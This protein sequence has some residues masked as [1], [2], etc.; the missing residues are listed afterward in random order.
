MQ[1]W[2]RVMRWSI[3]TFLMLFL[4]VS[5]VACGGVAKISGPPPLPAVESLPNPSLPD[6]IEQISPLGQAEPLAQVR[7]LFKEALI[8]I[9]RLDSPNQQDLLKKFEIIPPIAGQF[10]FLTPRMVGFQ[11]EE[12]LPKATRFRVTLKTGLGDLKNHR[13]DRDLIWTFNTEPIKFTNLPGI[14]QEQTEASPIDLKPVLTANA[15]V[16]LDLNSLQEHVQLIP[17]QGKPIAVKAALK[18]NDADEISPQE[19]FDPSTRVWTYTLTPQ[20]QL[21]KATPYRLEFQ[22]GIR[23]QRGNLATAS[24]IATSVSTYAPLKFEGLKYVG[25]PDASGAYGR[26]TQGSAQ[27]QF[28]NP[29]DPTS[30]A[31]SIRLNPAPKEAP[32]LVQSYEGERLVN[33]NPWALDPAKTYSVTID[34]NLKDQFGQSLGQSVTVKYATGDAAADI[35]APNNLNI[36]PVGKDLE[37][38][39]ETINLP[40][41]QY[42]AAF[43]VIQPQELVYYDSAYPQGE[44]PELLPADSNW[45]TYR[46]SGS[47][48]NQTKTLTVPL[49]E[50]LGGPTGMLAYGIKARTNRY[51]EEGKQKW[52][53]PKTYGMV[54]VTNLGVFTQWFPETG[55]IRVHHLSDGSPV[56]NA[57]IEVY[58]SRLR[59]ADR[60][61]PT[62]C[63]TGK[64]DANGTLR[65]NSADVTQCIQPNRNPEESGG[66]EVL[67]I[68]RENRDWAFARVENYSGAYGYGLDAGWQDGKP[69]SRGTIF[70]D[71]Q[72]YQP[73]E[74]AWFTGVAYYLQNDQIQTDRTTPYRV[75]LRLPDGQTVDLGTQTT[76]EFGTFSLEW[77]IKPDQ[78]LGF[79]TI[80]AKGGSG[81]EITGEFRVAEF[82]PPNFKVDLNLDRELVTLNQKVEAKTQSNYLFGSPVEGG[83][84]QYY[85][86]REA[87]DFKPKG[88]DPFSFGQQWFWPEEKPRVGNEVLLQTGNLSA[89]GQSKQSIAVTQDLPYPMIYRV[90]AQVTDVSN[91]SVADSKTFTVLPSDRLIGLQSDFVADAEK[92]FSVQVVV[93]DPT[94]KP[95]EGQTVKLELQQ[96]RY[97]AVTR[98]VE[99]S[100]DASNQ[101]EY[102]TVGQTDVRSGNQPQTVSLTPP[103][104]GSYRIRANFKD[105][106]NEVAVTDVQIWATGNDPV[107]WGGRYT[108]NRLEI[109]LDKPTYQ[110]G[111]TATALIQSPYPEAELYFAVVRHNTLYQ[112]VVKVQGSAPQVQFQ[113]TPDMLPNAAV[114]AVLVR[115][116]PPLAQ[117]QPGSLENLVK[118]GFAPFK[119]SVA[120][121][122]LQVQITPQQAELQPGAEQTL[123][124]TLQDLQGQPVKGQL[125][126]V[127]VNEAI[128]Q[129]SGY[130]LPDLVETVYAEQPIS[131]RFADNRPN[132]VLEPIASPL[133][134]GWGYGGGKSA[135]IANTRVRKNFQPLAF[136][137]GAIVTNDQG[138]AQV[139]FKLPDDL[140]TW[141]VMAVAMTSDLRFGRSD[142]TFLTTQPLLSNPILP[143]FARPGDR[144]QV[145]LAVTNTTGQS[146]TINL[147][148]NLNG[149]LQF[150]Q[151]NPAP[152]T[153]SQQAQIGSGTSAYRFPIVVQS[154]GEAKVSFNTQLNGQQSDAFEVPLPIQTLEVTEQVVETGTTT[155][156]AKIP[157]NLDQ[158]VVPNVGGL[159]VS[160]ASTLVSAIT[161][162]A[163]QVLDE[164]ELPFLEP[165]ASQLAIAANL[166]TLTRQY[167]QTIAKFNAGQQAEQAMTRL[168][169]L[170][171]SDGGFANWPQQEKSDP[172]V[173]AYAAQAIANAQR[174]GLRVDPQMVSRLQTYLKAILANPGQFEFC[175]PTLCKNQI[176]LAALTALA[177]LG[178][179]RGD[180][181]ADLYGDRNNLDLVTQIRL[182]RHLARFPEWQSEATTLTNQLQEILYQSGRSTQINLPQSWRWLNS[183]TTAQ[184]EAVRLFITQKAKPE[185]IDRLVRGLLELRRQGT[186]QTSYDN[187]VALTALVDYL[188]LQPTPPNFTATVQLGNQS[189]GTA[190]FEGYQQP[191][192]SL[193]MPMADLPKGRRELTLQK[194]GQ[195][196]LH[197]LVSY[198]YR[199]N[200]PQPGRL[201]GLRVVRSIHPANQKQ[202]IQRFGLYPADRP[203]TLEAGQVFDIG[204]EIIT[205]H[206]VDH[207]LITDPLPAGLEAVDTSFQTST[208]YFQ[209]QSDSWQLNYQ[210]IHRDRVVAYADRLEAGVYQLHYLVRSVTPGTY[211]WPGGEA[212]LQYAPEEFGR[213]ATGTLVVKGE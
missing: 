126:I 35:W 184:A 8:P 166:Q 41:Q 149:P 187:A 180:F 65:L 146:G 57:A 67:V 115:Q 83:K 87:T 3:G 192:T 114:E 154:S 206:P 23:P 207:V 1:G 160:I 147:T 142:T 122:H 101:V 84:V 182:A 158:R 201:N 13:L 181:L 95:I 162:P 54:Q 193:T 42:R 194:S 76:N 30:A 156:T 22:P 135:G 134:K 209:A 45:Q 81:N 97:S 200:G 7:I 78:P 88:W 96:M 213:T 124:L 82:K 188:Q 47:R 164:T 90:D 69:E 204:L 75:T 175:K 170:Q 120:A 27:L 9:E 40:D 93:V 73:G 148:S 70:S 139:S 62:P 49:R 186:W 56:A 39:I 18:Q 205:D 63:A 141:R 208:P 202:V 173:S 108:N 155:R 106:R 89:T 59:Q 92:P 91:L 143:Q 51:A 66:P 46:I 34:G 5:L 6:W 157:L 151:N 10:R 44:G 112:Q 150:E 125:T 94:G 68:A 103:E 14:N 77:A 86:T 174:A 107:N 191:S 53:E 140:T 116:G 130:R 185:T 183:A 52:R 60:N 128:L 190:R 50:Q 176:R 24:P 2:Q 25:Q 113:V 144:V 61:T 104:P 55:L 15:N 110:P 102:K 17:R 163:E 26:F 37:L 32:K 132:V 178:E 145:G 119:T 80:T 98:V 131:T 211:L 172:F 179:V 100:R 72:L 36:F 16:E 138:Q 111:E 196:T 203:L 129:L 19:Q 198:R 210:T 153:Q 109:R 189:I 171:R 31:Q 64:T 177:D 33:L 74:K 12:A 11:A 168:T 71:R 29:I 4:V 169:K 199:L 212:H 38:N 48:K 152:Q 165:A 20:K 117:V 43:Q 99:G 137:R 136:Y 58:K 161:A 121:K 167:G 85:V 133:E 79:Y 127:A 159:Q 123:Q 195:G 118:I 105:A 197:Y 21:S 28:N